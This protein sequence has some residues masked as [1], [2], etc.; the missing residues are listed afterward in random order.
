[1]GPFG[2]TGDNIT[3]DVSVDNRGSI[4]GY[5]SPDGQQEWL[6]DPEVRRSVENALLFAV[7]LPGTTFGRPASGTVRIMLR[8]SLIDVKG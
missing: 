8:R 4:T 2:F 3:I 6:N 7:I 5:S 1:M